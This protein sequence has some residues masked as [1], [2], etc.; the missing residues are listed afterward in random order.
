MI[1]V[2][3]GR[4]VQGQRVIEV[5]TVVKEAKELG[6]QGKVVIVVA[7]YSAQLV[8]LAREMVRVQIEEVEIA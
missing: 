3:A 4:L 7:E 6:E 5:M 1:V 2:K 8:G